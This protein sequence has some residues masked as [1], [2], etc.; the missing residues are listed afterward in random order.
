MAK[1]RFSS[2]AEAFVKSLTEGSQ[3]T[4]PYVTLGTIKTHAQLIV[5]MPGIVELDLRGFAKYTFHSSLHTN[6]AN[7]IGELSGGNLSV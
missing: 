2:K 4:I 3:L 7:Y 1:R 5:I 6:D